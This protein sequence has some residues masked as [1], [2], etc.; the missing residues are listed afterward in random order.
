MAA[1]RTPV[2]PAPPISPRV[3]FA[4]IGNLLGSLIFLRCRQ[5][6]L[7]HLL[8]NERFSKRGSRPRGGVETRHS[9][10][11]G[12]RGDLQGDFSIEDFSQTMSL[13]FPRS[14]VRAARSTRLSSAATRTSPT[15]RR[16]SSRLEFMNNETGEIKSQTVFAGD[17]PLMTDKGNLHHQ[18][19]RACCGVTSWFVRLVSTSSRRWT[20]SLTRTSSSPRSS[21]AA[22]LGSSSRSTR[23]DMVAVRVDCKRKQPVT[24]LLKALGP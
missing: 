20:R 17:F 8:G 13:S 18:R 19:H 12:P 10:D 23:R 2:S 5:R 22:V 16:C 7:T 6:R 21:R 4:K 3:S 1:L 15:Q 24:V 9:N 11:V 14:P